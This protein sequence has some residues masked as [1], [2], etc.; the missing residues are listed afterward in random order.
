MSK[1]IEKKWIVSINE[2]I[3]DGYV[4][5]THEIEQY[6][7]EITKEYEHRFRKKNDKYYETIKRGSG[8]ER[9]E[10][11]T[12]IT[13]EHYLEQEKNIKGIKIIKERREVEIENGLVCEI[14]KYY[15][16]RIDQ[17]SIM[18]IEFKDKD[19]ANNFNIKIL[20]N[21]GI[22][23]KKDITTLSQYKNKNIAMGYEYKPLY[24]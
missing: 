4:T 23:I 13:K 7:T 15:N 24:S 9:E 11:E 20:E 12:E 19:Q 5:E 16:P 21:Y 17:E 10:I 3:L 18:E 8:L 1:E 14:D 22:V 6:Y 2:D